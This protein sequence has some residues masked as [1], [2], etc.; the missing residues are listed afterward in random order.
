MKKTIPALICFYLISILLTSCGTKELL[1]KNDPVTLTMWHVFGSQAYSPMND[2]VSEFNRTVGQ[3]KGVVIKVISVSNSSDIH[4][5]L[6]AAA[7]GEAGAGTLPDLFF[8]YPE[9]AKAIGGE[10]IVA[11]NELFSEQELSEYVAAFIE[12]GMADGNLIVFPVAK[13]SEALFVNST[14]FDRFSADTGITYENLTTWDGLIEAAA[15]YYDWSGGQ[16]FL[17][18]DEILQ[19]CQIN[20]QALGGQ[21]FVGDRL[22]FDDP[23]FRAQWESIAKAVIIGHQ[24]MEDNYATTCMMTGDIIAAIGSTASILYFNDTVT[25]RDNTTES[26]TLAVLPCPVTTGGTKMVIQ[27]G[28]GLASSVKGD[29]RKEAAALLFTKWITDGEINLRFVTQAGYMPVKRSAFDAISD[30]PFENDTYRDLYEAMILMR[31]DYEFY[32]SPVVDGY[33]DILT[34]FFYSSLEVLGTYKEL[35]ETGNGPPEALASEA[36]EA[37][38]QAMTD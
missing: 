25:Y 6:L 26:L 35:H 11:W 19:F 17:M 13:S 34:K 24:R 20:T 5:A 9:T 2:M 16:S 28:V 8:C 37:L 27:Q 7:N 23:I 31:N 4:A 12:E 10:R 15:G 38:R 36:Y 22:N 32:L 3:E 1:T 33:Y 29:E 18:H 14:I 21:S 30:F